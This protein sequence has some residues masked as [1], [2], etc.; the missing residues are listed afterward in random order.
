M[1]NNYINTQYKEFILDIKKYFEDSEEAIHNARNIIKILNFNHQKFAVKSFKVPNFFNKIIYTFFRKSKAQKSYDHSIKLMNLD[2]DLPQ[3]IGYIEYYKNG[4]IETSYFVSEYIKYDF[5]IKE[6]LRDPSFEYRDTILE[7]FVI[8][9]YSLHKKGV[10]HLDYS[11][12]NILIKTRDKKQYSFYIVDINRMTFNTT[13]TL[14][15]R[16]KNFNMLWLLDTDAISIAKIY[17]TISNMNEVEC[18]DKILYYSQKQKN[19]KRR[20]KQLKKLIGK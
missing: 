2:I 16:M 15:E 10:Y 9:T 20:K 18:I 7:Q 14:N 19:F 6:V 4:L 13:L 1:K 12:G 8:F 3:P 17:A 5:T 11:A